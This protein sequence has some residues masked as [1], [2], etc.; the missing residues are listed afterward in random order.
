MKIK[1]L[2]QGTPFDKYKDLSEEDYMR[3]VK[4]CESKNFVMNSEYMQWL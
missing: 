3:L 2:H 1:V 4:K